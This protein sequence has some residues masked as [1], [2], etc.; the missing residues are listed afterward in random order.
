MTI[1][2]DVALYFARQMRG[3]RAQVQAD[4]E[5]YVAVAIAVEQLAAALGAKGGACAAWNVIV[6][7]L[8]LD[9][10]WTGDGG[11][12]SLGSASTTGYAVRATS[13]SMKAPCRV[14]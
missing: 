3:A 9:G 4:A 1:Q 11:A 7:T 6:D 2:S 12:P 13:P 10:D 5:G 8:S 14:P